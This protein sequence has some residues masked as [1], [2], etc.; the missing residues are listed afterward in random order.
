M[1]RPAP[2]PLSLLVFSLLL[3]VGT[4]RASDWPEFRGALRDGRST[5]TGLLKSWPAAGPK[6]L[7][8]V[9]I[10]SAFSAVVV[11]DG[12]VITLDS[13]GEDEFAV[14]LDPAT[15]KELWR[16][17][18]G[19]IF[20][21]EWGDGP[22]SAPLVAEGT[23]YAVGARGTLH[24]LAAA[25]GMPRWQVD[26]PT[27]FGSE[28]PTWGFAMTPIVVGDLLIT[29]VAGKDVSIAAFDK[30]SGELRWT[31][32][33]DGTA[34]SSPLRITAG[35]VDHL[36]FMTAGHVLGVAFDGKVLWQVPFAPEIGIKPAIPLFVAP[37]LLIFSASYDVGAL[38]LRLKA[39]G[40]GALTAEQAWRNRAMRNHFNASVL[41]GEKIYGFDNSALK[42][43]DAATGEA[44][45]VQRGG[46]FGK[47]SLIYAD[48]H[49]V[50]LSELGKLLLVESTPE[51]Y[52]EKGAVQLL[53]EGRSWTSP[54][55]AHG[56]LYIRNRNELICLDWRG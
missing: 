22:R 51:A 50:L 4:A 48:G 9:P 42:C 7:W 15:G 20:R 49:L 54:T 12:R 40:P 10:G 21:E 36:V 46:N 14:A 13:A 28:L 31:T 8:R 27:R 39:A 38:A 26:F 1:P 47:G 43:L 16:R 6:V 33:K 45:W 44:C 3:A 35:G 53:A 32:H 18:I 41:V 23:V 30:T 19:P 24:A 25:D 37:D 56:R 29:E 52:R 55:L 34:Y 5:E 11:A 17:R 2:K